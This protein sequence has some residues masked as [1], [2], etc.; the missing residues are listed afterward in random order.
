[1]DKK[2]KISSKRKKI[3]NTKLI[4][5]SCIVVII[6]SV[7]CV[8]FTNSESET[9]TVKIEQGT[10]ASKIAEILKDE[11]IINSKTYFL[12][13]LRFSKYNNKLKYGTFKLNTDD[14]I[15]ELFE[16]LSSKGEKGDT[17]LLT[18][19]EGYS[20]ER[21]KERVVSMGLCTN[22]EFEAALKKDY[23]FDFLN[24]I[25]GSKE[26]NYKLQGFLFPSTYEFYVNTNAETIIIT[27]LNEFKK[28]TE[29]LN[30]PND[31]LYDI[32][33]AASMVERE[34]KLPD[35][36]AKIAG[37]FKNRVDQDMPLQIDAT[38]V[39]AISDGMYNVER[40]YYKDLEVDSK[41]NT[42]KYPGLPIGP[43]CSPSIDSIKA[44][45][46]PEKHEFLFYHTDTDKNDG[47]HI[48]TKTFNEHIKTK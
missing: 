30:I 10:P 39:Y 16:T 6:I 12:T 2:A 33:T 13:R 11:G 14:S 23:D 35:E 43:I 21:I 44:A 42:Y 7:L 47:S 37:V 3:N 46:N 41:Y 5:I 36:R 9:I 40:V 4:I 38:V 26:I 48:F 15:N 28:Q 45:A 31:K 27:L 1:M 8:L 19:P 17:V 25:P 34:A 32:I 29:S 20:V 18:I 22:D 24:S